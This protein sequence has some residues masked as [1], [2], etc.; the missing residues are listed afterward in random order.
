M[1]NLKAISSSAT[2]KS[3]IAS[4]L[5]D[6]MWNDYFA[7]PMKF[8]MWLGS[9]AVETS[10]KFQSNWETLNTDLVPSNICEILL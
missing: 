5:Q 9:I 6:L 10:A 3:H 4:N 1:A 8:G 2:L 7:I